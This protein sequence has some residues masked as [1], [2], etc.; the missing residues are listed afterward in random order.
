MSSEATTLRAPA[1][2]FQAGWIISANDDLVYFIGSVVSGYALLALNR[3]WGVPLLV[4]VFVWA[5]V[6]DGPHVWATFSRTY[7]DTE[8]RRQRARLLYGCAFWFVL[9]PAL[10]LST[11]WSHRDVF[12]KSFFFFAN[13]WAYYHLVK[14]HYGFMVLYKKKNSDLDL[15]DNVLDRLFLVFLLG[16][17]FVWMIIS[18]GPAHDYLPLSL[19][20]R[21]EAAI[22]RIL[23]LA[24]LG[25]IFLWVTRQVRRLVGRVPIN[26]PKYLLLA[27]CIPLHWIVISSVVRANITPLALVPLLTLPHNI[28]Y[29][30]LVWFHNS[31]K[32]RKP[33]AEGRFGYAVFAN[34]T[35]LRYALFGLLFNFIYQL[36]RSF[37]GTTNN[38]MTAQSILAAF[39]WGYAF[40]H[41]YLDAKIW[42]VRRDP[43]L[44]QSLQ[45]TEASP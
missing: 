23:F 13:I 21:V 45:L 27:A 18:Y 36:P 11:Q 10:V 33:E 15:F 34:K 32:Y 19:G 41:Y 40:T 37:V 12:A 1:R 4:L 39:F 44:N 2:L 30:R 38:Y 43:A 42:R 9:G 31:N 26:L 24:M 29:H 25:V 6:F 17:P 8:E 14:Q 35:F 20:G 3:V 7:L 28:Q 16:Y 22:L 5:I